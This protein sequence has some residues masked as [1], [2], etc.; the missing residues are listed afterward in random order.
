MNNNTFFFGLLILLA[1]WFLLNNNTNEKVRAMRRSYVP[2]VMEEEEMRYNAE[3]TDEEVAYD[4]LD[5]GVVEGYS[6][7][8]RY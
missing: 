7:V 2:D 8:P 3:I 5:E 6:R 4:K 1:F